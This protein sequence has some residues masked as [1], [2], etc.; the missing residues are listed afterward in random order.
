MLTSLAA[1]PEGSG[2]ALIGR[3]EGTWSARVGSYRALYTI[4]PSGVIVRA[5]QHRAVVYRKP[6]R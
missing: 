4:E 3:L 5:I 2:K 1:N 6:V